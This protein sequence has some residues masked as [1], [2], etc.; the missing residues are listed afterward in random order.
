[1]I[2]AL[3]SR[4]FPIMWIIVLS[5]F[6]WIMFKEAQSVSMIRDFS[7][8]LICFV[9]F[10]KLFHCTIFSSIPLTNKDVQRGKYF[11]WKLRL[12][13]RRWKLY[14]THS[15]RPSYMYRM[16]QHFHTLVVVARDA[17]ASLL[18]YGINIYK[19]WNTTKCHIVCE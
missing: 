12:V 7:A 13:I 4:F 1:M 14:E 11:F 2:S 17:N 9:A 10:F 15:R 3:S 5:S 19:I 6:V 18:V 8:A 16:H